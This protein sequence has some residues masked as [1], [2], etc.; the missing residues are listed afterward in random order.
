MWIRGKHT[1]SDNNYEYGIS[2]NFA[3][4]SIAESISSVPDRV[5]AF[6]CPKVARWPSLPPFCCVVFK[7]TARRW[8]SP[9]PIDAISK[10]GKQCSGSRNGWKAAPVYQL[11]ARLSP[12][13]YLEIACGAY[14]PGRMM[15]SVIVYRPENPTS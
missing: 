4:K 9:P 7:R 3:R 15:T 8:S 1:E 6:L 11:L 14:Y 2:I 5:S 13:E 12:R 10:R